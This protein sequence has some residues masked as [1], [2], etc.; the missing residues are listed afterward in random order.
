[1][2]AGEHWT[3]DGEGSIHIVRNEHGVPHV[4]AATEPDLYRGLGYCHATD[5][6]LQMLLTRI[7]AQGR[8]SELLAAT[9]EML[10]LDTFFRRLNLAGDAAVESAKLIERHR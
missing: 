6:S 3:I 10:Q 4:R 8:G 7:L 5:R 2:R 9:D 1:M